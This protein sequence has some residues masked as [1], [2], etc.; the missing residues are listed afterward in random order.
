[1]IEN[2][3]KFENIIGS[4][5]DP[6][7]FRSIFQ[8]SSKQYENVKLSTIAWINPSVKFDGLKEN[9]EISFIPMEI[10]DEKNGVIT[11]K[12]FKKISETKGFTR[13]EDD[14]LLW[15]KIT[16]CMQNGKSAIAKNLK[17]KF[18]CG[19]TEFFVIRPKKSNIL[20]EYL[21]F[22]LRDNR[23]L[24]GAKYFFGGSAGQQRV[25]IDFLKNFRVP[26][27]PLGLQEDIVSIIRNANAEKQKKEAIAQELLA[28]IDSY[29]LETLG[30]NLTNLNSEKDERFLTVKISNLIGKRLDP[31]YHSIS[32][33]G[34]VIDQL[35]HSG[36]DVLY[37]K[38]I[39]EQVF[40]GIGKNETTNGEFKLLKVKNILRN[41]EIDYTNVEF[42]KTVP[43]N[44]LLQ[45]NDIITPFIGEA[46]KGVKFSVFSNDGKYTVDNNTGVIRLKKE[47]NP[48]YV[49]EYLCS[50]LGKIQLSRLSGGGGVPFL[51]SVNAKKLEI[52]IP[53]IEKQNE[54][55][56][57]IISDRVFAK[58]LQNISSKI[59]ETAKLQVEKIILEGK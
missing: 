17:N 15:A 39:S 54:I 51:G 24:E 8:F 36:Y 46:I 12:R 55:A 41:N 40:Q 58:E 22:L 1:M 14:D 21:H 19:S 4:R 30:I 50:S 35:K 28:N 52:I 27:I 49:A 25:S 6:S 20:I 33:Y 53:P 38:D 32:K 7:S 56:N 45:I 2:H 31:D 23:V 37:L 13:F 42:V 44:K 3:I 10:I 48:I 5:L 34:N 29:I 57:Q 16:P 47:V 26:L 9:D 11:E 59:I 43:D 18:G